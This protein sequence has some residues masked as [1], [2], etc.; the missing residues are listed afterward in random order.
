MNRSWK[1]QPSNDEEISIIN[2]RL[3]DLNRNVLNID[4][5]E[6]WRIPL[7]YV[8]KMENEIIAGVDAALYPG[9]DVLYI[10]T[11]FV[12]QEYRGSGLGTDLLRKVEQDAKANGA[13]ISRLDSLSW[14]DKD[15][16]IKLGYEVFAMLEDCPVGH[17]YYYLKK[18]L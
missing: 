14:H 15:F 5:K 9:C 17:T 7:R 6:P 13:T 3:L 10:S 4:S 12:N 18:K 2:D 8:V 1:I 16:Y 11:L